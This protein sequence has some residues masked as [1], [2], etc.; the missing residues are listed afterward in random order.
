MNLKDIQVYLQEQGVDGWLLY[1][2]RDLNPIAISVAGLHSGGSRRWFL[3]IPAQGAPRWLIHAIEGNMFLDADP[4]LT[5]EQIRYVSWQEMADCLPRLIGAEDGH[6]PKIFMEYSPGNA[7]PFIS[8]VDAGIMEV[9]VESTGAEILSSADIAQLALAVLTPEQVASHRRA[10]AVCLAAKDSG[11]DLIAEHLRS[12][13]PIMEHEVQ[14]H[15][16]DFFA[17]AGMQPLLP[18]VSVNAN[19]ADPH[20]FPS[21]QRPVAISAGDVVLIDLWT[22]EENNPEMS[23]ADLTW[24]AYCGSEVPDKVQH[25]FETVIAG[26]D[27]AV[28]FIQ[29][30]LDAGKTV[31]GYEVD[32]ACRQVIAGAGY[33]DYFIHRTGH[34]LGPTG[35]YLGVNIDNLETQD[36]RVLAPGVMFTIEPGIYMPAFNFDDGPV[37]KGLGIRSEINCYMLEDRVE[38]TTLPLQMEMR[39]LLR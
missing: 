16:A 10:A 9:V 12:G 13:R 35:H 38:V 24:T 29:D 8:R 37:A 27:R 2:F 7:I 1:N 3:W 26:R 25:V 11:F 33:G 15:I 14:Q 5:G 39:P 23:E 21:A 4:A 17:R 30:S 34:S 6:Q 32:D 18:I 19:A 22:G 36:R 28:A 31:H 20:Y